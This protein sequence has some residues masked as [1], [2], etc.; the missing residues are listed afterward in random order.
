MRGNKSS[1]SKRLAFSSQHIPRWNWILGINLGS[2]EAMLDKLANHAA[3][4]GM[5]FTV[6]IALMYS[7]YWIK[8]GVFFLTLA[9]SFLVA[10]RYSPQLVARARCLLGGDFQAKAVYLVLASCI[11]RRDKSRLSCA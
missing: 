9:R 5:F 4:A 7:W 2:S 1:F 8:K 6:L 11:R 3:D 10:I